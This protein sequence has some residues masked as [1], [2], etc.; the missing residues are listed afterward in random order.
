M[1]S[2]YSDQGYTNERSKQVPI[3]ILSFQPAIQSLNAQRL[4]WM[5]MQ[6][7]GFD[8]VRMRKKV[9]LNDFVRRVHRNLVY[10]GQGGPW[11]R[12]RLLCLRRVWAH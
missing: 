1:L 11:P 6:E 3:P 2:G 4:H 12:I 5:Q 7:L 10:R 9:D 8:K